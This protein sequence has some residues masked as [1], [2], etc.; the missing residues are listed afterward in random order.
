MPSAPPSQPGSA[1]EGARRTQG[2]VRRQSDRL[3]TKPAVT[4]SEHRCGR[5]NFVGPSS[6]YARRAYES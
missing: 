3:E 6:S 4:S 1:V 5:E 2:Q